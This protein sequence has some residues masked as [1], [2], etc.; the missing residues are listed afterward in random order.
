MAYLPHVHPFVSVERWMRE[1]VIPRQGVWVAEVD[2]TAFAIRLASRWL[3]NEPI[4]PSS[5]QRPGIGGALLTEI[6]KYALLAG[7]RHVGDA[8]IQSGAAGTTDPLSKCH[9]AKY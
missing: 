6:K 9:D 2:R 1:M 7:S 4:R 3:F 5:H 8:T